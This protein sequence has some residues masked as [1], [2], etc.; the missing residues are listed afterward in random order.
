VTAAKVTN[1]KA[2]AKAKATATASGGF[3]PATIR[4][5]AAETDDS[6]VLELATP[7]EARIAWRSGQHV[8][9]RIAIDGQDIYRTYSIC[10]ASAS[11]RIKLGV[12]LLPNGVFS[13]WLRRCKT[14]DKLAVSRPQGRFYLRPAGR[15]ARHLFIA[16]GSGITPVIGMLEEF[17]GAHADST[18]LLL[19]ANRSIASTMFLERLMQ[20]KN[21]FMARFE[22]HFFTSREPQAVAWRGRRID[23]DALNMLREKNLL[24]VD[25]FARCY[26]CGPPP[27]MESCAGFLRAHGAPAARIHREVFAAARRLDAPASQASRARDAIGGAAAVVARVS[28]TINGAQRAFDFRADDASVLAAAARQ[29]IAL[30]FACTDGVCG[31]CRCKILRGRIALAQN[32]AL[33]PADI[34]A[35]F[36]LACQARP[37]GDA[38]AL[39]FD[40]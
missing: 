37:Q 14:G 36:T 18:A 35:G 9:L 27:M 1:A 13:D 34:D 32:H 5:I 24:R 6:R 23:A 11:G 3:L 40:Y 4:A 30:P 26:L 38:L 33:E 20:L 31:T 19:Y 2:K 16:A 15:R 39:S 7:G 29:R 10:E 17:L 28:V 21:R 8:S 25:D 22:L 12:R